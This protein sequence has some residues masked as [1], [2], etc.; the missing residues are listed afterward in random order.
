MS[1]LIECCH[2]FKTMLMLLGIMFTLAACGPE[3]SE[4]D[5]ALD[6]VQQHVERIQWNE[7]GNGF[8]TPNRVE[9]VNLTHRQL[10]EKRHGIAIVVVQHDKDPKA[11]KAMTDPKQVLRHPMSFYQ[12]VVCPPQEILDLYG[13]YDI[14]INL[15]S[16]QFNSFYRVPCFGM[17]GFPPKKDK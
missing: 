14:Y 17:E 10:W 1:A 2:P 6:A 7:Y 3:Q 11:P 12:K 9:Y 5:N 15:L 8:Y 13:D 16:E 4:I